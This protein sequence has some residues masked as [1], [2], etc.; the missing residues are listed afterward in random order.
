MVSQRFEEVWYRNLREP[1]SVIIA[2]R[3]VCSRSL[4][5]LREIVGRRFLIR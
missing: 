1:D 4:D 2:G 3:I 5:D